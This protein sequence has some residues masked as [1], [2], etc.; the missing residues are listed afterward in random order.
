MIDAVANAPA[1]GPSK[2]EGKTCLAM[3]ESDKGRRG[4]YR[5]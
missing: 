2:E 5:W 3:A 1:A 4:H